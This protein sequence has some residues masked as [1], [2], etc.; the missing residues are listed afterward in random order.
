VTDTASKILKKLKEQK[1]EE[2]ELPLLLE[3]YQELVRLQDTARKRL[4][5]PA[6]TLDIDAIKARLVQ[7]Q[8]LVNDTGLDLDPEQVKRLFE[9]VIAVFAAY[10]QL[11]GEL[12]DSLQKPGAGRLLT[13]EVV[14]KW[15]NGTEL[16]RG[17]QE[18]ASQPLLQAIMLATL[19]PFLAG[20]ARA[21]QEHLKP[22]LLETWRRGC[23]PVCGGG[24]DIAYLE[25][26]V[27]ARWLVCSRCDTEWLFQ[28]LQCP[29]CGTVAQDALSYFADDTELYRLYVCEKCKRY[30]KAIDLRKTSDEILLPLERLYTSEM[31]RQARERGY[32]SPA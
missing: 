8:P 14:K 24:P 22:D 17:L 12:P 5:P 21:Y 25:K 30:L 2:G 10:P 28:R 9:E 20:Y 16:P 1:K 31:D 26:E 4:T 6:A 29:F 7:G 3:F 11:F 19:Q 23:C 13:G 18:N 32:G 27:G 15:F